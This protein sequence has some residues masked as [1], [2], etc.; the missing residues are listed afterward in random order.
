M[1]YNGYSTLLNHHMP[2][3]YMKDTL[4]EVWK[5]NRNT[6]EFT[7][8]SRFRKIS[9]I[10]QYIFRYWQLV[11]GNFTPISMK[12]CKNMNIFDGEDSDKKDKID[13]TD[14]AYEIIKNQKYRMICI[15]DGYASEDTFNKSKNRINEAFESILPEKSSFELD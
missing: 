15:N 12:D 6:L 5:K 9:D 3:S 11:T 1:S 10:N 2:V 13:K 14:T 8:K 4:F 7:S